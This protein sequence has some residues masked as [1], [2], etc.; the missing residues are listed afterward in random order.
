MRDE[1]LRLGSSVPASRAPLA[2]PRWTAFDER[3]ILGADL[4]VER[5]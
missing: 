1:L 3:A 4:L 5:Q 2:I